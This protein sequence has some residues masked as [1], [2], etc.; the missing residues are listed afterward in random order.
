M[1]RN[2]LP[3]NQEILQVPSTYLCKI[4]GAIYATQQ[5]NGK[6]AILYADGHTVS[7]PASYRI[8]D[9]DFLDNINFVEYGT[10]PVVRS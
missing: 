6:I 10:I 9:A 1:K 8:E 2:D 5:R 7:R 4:T 3:K